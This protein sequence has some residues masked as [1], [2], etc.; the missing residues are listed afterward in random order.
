MT[1]L[2][3]S[4]ILAG[5]R[6]RKFYQCQVICQDGEFRREVHLLTEGAVKIVKYTAKGDAVNLALGLPGEILCPGDMCRERKYSCSV[7]SLRTT[8]AFVW[9]R[10]GFE[11][12][13]RTYPTL[14][15]NYVRIQQ[16]SLWE[17]EERFCEMTTKTVSQRLAAQLIRLHGRV[18]SATGLSE[19]CASREDL[20]QMTGTTTFSASR[21]LSEWEALGIIK[22]R[23]H[24][25][26]VC[27]E[28]AL[29]AFC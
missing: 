9:S 24:S 20:A 7:I 12:F 18:N 10:I 17:M 13:L 11:A 1:P 8:Q 6:L 28:K 5:A 15:R 26:T 27:D 22:S 3:R 21:T 16:A 19:I 4:H 14:F 2:E 23:R 29:S 25:V